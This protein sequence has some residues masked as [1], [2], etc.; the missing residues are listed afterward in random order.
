[1]GGVGGR[2][3]GG[4]QQSSGLADFLIHKAVI[5]LPLTCICGEWPTEQDAY[6]SQEHSQYCKQQTKLC[7]G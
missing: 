2:R 7:C 1:M 3:G 6:Q 4:G 5:A